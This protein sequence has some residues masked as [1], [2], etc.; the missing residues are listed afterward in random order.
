M[1]KSV[2]FDSI[3]SNIP[4]IWVYS[5]EEHRFIQD[6]YQFLTAS[7][8]VSQFYIYDCRGKIMNLQ[9]SEDPD[10]D[11]A[12]YKEYDSPKQAIE[13]FSKPVLDDGTMPYPTTKQYWD[14]NSYG[15]Q[16]ESVLVLL[17]VPFYMVDSAKVNHTNAMLTRVIKSCAVQ[18]I[19]QKKTLVFVNHHKV[20]PIELE[21]MVTYVEHELPKLDYLKKIVINGMGFISDDKVPKMTLDEEGIIKVA[22]QL[23][24]LTKFQA[25]NV[26]AQANR[27]NA[28]ECFSNKNTERGFKIEVI[29]NEKARLI[30][31]STTLEL[32]EPKFDLDG[33]GGIENLKQWAK[34]REI[35]FRHEAREDGID[36]PKGVLLIGPGGTGK[37]LTAQCL[38]K[39]W[40][41]PLLRL[42]ISACMGSL[43]GESEGNLIKALKD[44]E[45]QAPCV[46]F[47][48]SQKFVHVKY[49][50][51]A[52]TLKCQPEPKAY[53]R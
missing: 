6:E 7:N 46:L 35:V 1:S 11:D 21:P 41:R 39:Q 18:N 36:M 4:L 26:L 27:K 16:E 2:L 25:E 20:I 23:K 31:K 34:D 43:L 24:G 45:A 49:R 29:Q 42:D 32:I 3:K 44:A 30:S 5:L 10:C 52:G 12:Q 19:P 13:D 9:Y 17:D 33:V 48:D 38:A 51:K 28:I 15:F 50:N 37:S 8:A 47:V 53:R 22:N 14:I 40:Q